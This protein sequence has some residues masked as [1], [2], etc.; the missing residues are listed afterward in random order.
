MLRR[1]TLMVLVLAVAL[2]AAAPALAGG[3]PPPGL[4]GGDRARPVIY[5]TSQGLYYDSIVGPAL[6]AKGPFQQLEMAGPTGL[7]TEFID[8]ILA[9]KQWLTA[10][11]LVPIAPPPQQLVK[12]AQGP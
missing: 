10:R 7:Q 1:G 3:G 12:Q 11:L 5:V 6:P 2:A 4:P 8:D 9:S